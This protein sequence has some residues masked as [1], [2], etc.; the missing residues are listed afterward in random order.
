MMK[1]GKINIVVGAIGLLLAAIGGMALGLTFDKQA[2]KDGYHVLSI[3][4]VYFRDAHSHGMA[5]CVYNLFF[6]LIIDRMSFS[7]KIK[8]F[9]SYMAAC[10]LILP[11]SL[12][13][14]A[15]AGAPADFPPIG[16]LGAIAFVVSICILLS[17]I[18]KAV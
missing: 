18:K 16:I 17:G 10:S 8:K 4:R 14:R 7:D 9:G 2:I 6:G 12:L 3:V 13:A 15:F 1:F 5:F 11:I